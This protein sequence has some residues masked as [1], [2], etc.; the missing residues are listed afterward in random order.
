MIKILFTV[1]SV[2]LLCFIPRGGA[3]ELPAATSAFL[4]N[5]CF[6]CHDAETK[7]GGLDLTAHTADFA[8]AENFS[9]WAR[10]YERIES[11]E[12]PPKK[13]ARPTTE[14]V[15]PVLAWL[16]RELTAADDARLAG[17]GRTA[18][19]RL[20]RVEYE[21]TMRD[22][23]DLP[24]IALQALLP[25]DGSAHGYDKNSE[26]LSISHVNL[27]KYLDAADHTLDLAIATRPRAP[28]VQTVRTSLLDRGGQGPY[29]SLQGD[30]VLL[31][32][33]KPDLRGTARSAFSGARMNR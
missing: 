20:T 32:D 17:T 16:K 33:M 22:L 7:K 10:I 6:D 29:L 11:G 18:L 26:A 23:F 28:R 25:P 14:E 8:N 5:R 12:M 1:A 13:K 21:N 3:A 31:R 24:G 27:S 9:R 19:R 4:E 30:V 2:A 15:T